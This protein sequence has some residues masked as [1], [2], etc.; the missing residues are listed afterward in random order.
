[1]SENV[2]PSRLSEVGFYVFVHTTLGVVGV[3]SL[4]F[5]LAAILSTVVGKWVTLHLFGPPVYFAPITIAFATG[6][7]LNRR[8]RS[9]SAEFTWFVGVLWLGVSVLAY[10]HI[11]PILTKRIAFAP[12]YIS[13]AYSLGSWIGYRQTRQ[14]PASGSKPSQQ[15]ACDAT[16]PAP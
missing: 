3:A 15:T 14:R 5:V 10:M 1:M 4:S 2:C 6:L 12:F 8:L 16:G 13:I 7:L 11:G 9:R